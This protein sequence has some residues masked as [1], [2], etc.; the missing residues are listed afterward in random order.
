MALGE[1]LT[2]A[3]A[4]WVTL[5]ADQVNDGHRFAACW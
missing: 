5:A 4:A 2:A 3:L 1:I